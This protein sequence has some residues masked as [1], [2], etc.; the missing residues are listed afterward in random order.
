MVQKV[1]TKV[2][3]TKNCHPECSAPNL[4]ALFNVTLKF[5]AECI[6]G[7]TDHRPKSMVKK[8]QTKV[9]ATKHC[10]PE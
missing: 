6:E 4:F 3:A 5:G 7:L 10:H 8:A 9:Y 1:Q 2:Y